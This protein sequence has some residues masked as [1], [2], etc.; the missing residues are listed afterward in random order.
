MDYNEVS[1][2][3]VATIRANGGEMLYNEFQETLP[4][5]VQLS[6]P[7]HLIQMQQ[8]GAVELSVRHNGNEQVTNLYINIPSGGG[9]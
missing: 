2:A 7:R 3:A 1:A 6:L 9:V 5:V 8:D 4:P